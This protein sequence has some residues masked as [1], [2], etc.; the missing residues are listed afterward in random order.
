[1]KLEDM[2]LVIE[3]RKG[4]ESIFLLNLSDYMEMV[5]KACE[6]SAIHIADAIRQLYDTKKKNDGCSEL[7]FRGNVSSQ[8]RF[9][10]SDGQLRGFLLGIGAEVENMEKPIFDESRCSKECFEVLKAYGIGTDGDSLF[11]SL[12]YEA[13]NYTFKQ[14]EILHNLNGCNYRVLSV[15]SEKNLLLMSMGDGQYIVADN[16]VM[17]ERYPKDGQPSGDSIIKGVEWGHGIY[18]GYDL[19]KI[20]F[21]GIVQKYG[22]PKQVHNT[23]DY[24]SELRWRFVRL[25]SLSQNTEIGQMVRWAAE[26]EL[27]ETYG[28]TEREKFEKNLE[29]GN[30]DKGF[31]GQEK[32]NKK[33]R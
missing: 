9:C 5:L 3:N 12:H 30:Y 1:M 26:K 2:I 17:Y 8:A 14:G 10:S 16:T 23:G 4:T 25:K 27:L 33:S 22:R 29:K 18:L 31:H 21:D 13:K 7:Y 32:S 20:D 11:N 28:T 6:N 19:M 15:L 24:R